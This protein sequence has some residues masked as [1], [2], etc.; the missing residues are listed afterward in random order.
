MS[1][2]YANIDG[3]TKP[4]DISVTSNHTAATTM[5]VIECHSLDKNIGD[6]IEI[7]LGYNDDIETVFTG[8]IKQIEK[9]VPDNTYIVTAHDVLTRAV[10]FFVVSSDP[11]SPFKRR[12]IK[13]EDLV[14][15]VL[16]LAGL[17]N[18]DMKASHFTLAIGVDAEVNLVS[19]YDYAKSIVDLVAYNLWADSA[20]V[21]HFANRKPYVMDGDPEEESEQAG[22]VQDPPGYET[23]IITDSKILKY[24][25]NKHERDL[26]NRIVVYG[27]ENTHKDASKAT[28]YD[29]ISKEYVQVLPS[30]F[31]KSVV[32]AS[33]L[34]TKGSYMQQACDYNLVML[35]RL[36]YEIGLTI[37]GDP[38]CIA[39]RVVEIDS[40][41]MGIHSDWYIYTSEINWGKGGF[42][43]NLILRK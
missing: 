1:I 43:N 19:A 41:S 27:N 42:T 23:E 14:Q 18:F 40:T 39:R 13:A 21:V 22:Y 30:G 38:T 31:Y 29:P 16:E 6:S 12:N 25:Y 4:V 37:V 5:A 28:S 9:K 34:L 36:N 33:P 15:D 10:D 20:G 26:R 35:N 7:D 32:F 8:Y 2:L 24:T 11:E 3:L 17:N